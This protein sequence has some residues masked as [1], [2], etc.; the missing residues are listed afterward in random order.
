MKKII[1]TITTLV[2]LLIGSFSSYTLYKTG[3]IYNDSNIKDCRNLWFSTLCSGTAFIIVGIY[4]SM[5]LMWQCMCQV[6]CDGESNGCRFTCCKCI[7]LVGIISA[8][9]WQIT[10]FIEQNDQ[11]HQIYKYKYQLLW[12][13]FY[14]QTIGLFL[15]IVIWLILCIIGYFNKKKKKNNTNINNKYRQLV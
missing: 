9:V 12:L 5:Y 7:L 8:F 11:C 13:C 15:G 1:Q 10:H 4:G 6:L 14:I 2:C 3:Y